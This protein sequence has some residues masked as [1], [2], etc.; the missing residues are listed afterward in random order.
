[1]DRVPVGNAALVLGR[2]D[3]VHRDPSVKLWVYVDDLDAHFN[4][5]R[6]HGAV[7]VEPIHESGFRSYE[8]EDPAGHRWI[9][10]QARPTM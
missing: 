7:V 2:G 8:A 9:V 6:E 5:A 1:M 4:Q 3:E 10:A